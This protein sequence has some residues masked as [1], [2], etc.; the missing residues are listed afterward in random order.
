MDTFHGPYFDFCL[1]LAL[2]TWV[3]ALLMHSLWVHN[4]GDVH[5][6]V[7]IQ[8]SGPSNRKALLWTKSCLIPQ[9]W[10]P[11]KVKGVFS[12]PVC[13]R[14]QTNGPPVIDQ[15]SCNC[16]HAL[17]GRAV[18]MIVHVQAVDTRPS[19]SSRAAWVQG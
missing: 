8:Y 4:L 9:K 10:S 12:T 17:S 5:S 19:F 18:G 13:T 11:Y 6:L 2:E 15:G 14:K 1:K 7:S 16:H 3:K